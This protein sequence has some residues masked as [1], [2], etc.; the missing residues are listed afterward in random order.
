MKVPNIKFNQLDETIFIGEKGII[1]H[2]CCKCKARHVWIVQT[3]SDQKL[4]PFTE[5]D[6]FSDENGTKLRRFYESQKKKNE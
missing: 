1:F 4:G 6:I 5:I 2:S 3:H